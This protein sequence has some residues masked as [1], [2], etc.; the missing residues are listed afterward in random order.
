MNRCEWC[1]SDALYVNYHDREW[2]VPVHDDRK[3]FEM[4]TLEGAQAGLSWSTILKKRNNYRKAFDN[5]DFNKIAKYGGKKISKLMKNEGIV[6]NKLKINATVINAKAFLEV[7]KE[8]GT[9]DK[10]IWR[11]VNNNPKINK[12]KSLKELPSKT[13]ESDLMDEDLKKRGFKFIGSTICYAFMQAVGM[14]NDHVV[15]CYRWKA[16]K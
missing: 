15:N 13:K 1:G 9:F 11:F 10:Y 7:R 14:T 16:L 8:F 6:R 12:F 2:G 4:L 5:F 3:L